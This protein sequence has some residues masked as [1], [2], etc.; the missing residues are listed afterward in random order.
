M[1]LGA[2][3]ARLERFSTVTTLL[4]LIEFFVMNAERNLPQETIF[5]LFMR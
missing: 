4:Y 3:V 1:N 5:M 2:H